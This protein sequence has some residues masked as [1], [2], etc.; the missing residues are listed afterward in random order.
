MSCKFSILER[1]GGPTPVDG[2]LLSLL[3]QS[4]FVGASSLHSLSANGEAK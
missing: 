1:R 3:G 4:F 2:G